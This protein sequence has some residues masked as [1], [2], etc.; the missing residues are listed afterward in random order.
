MNVTISNQAATDTPADWLLLGITESEELGEALQTIDRALG[1]ILTRLQERGDLT[2]KAN[3]L[4]LLP[5]V[6]G[7]QAD[8]MMIVGLGPADRMSRASFAKSMSTAIRRV[9]TREQQTLA[10]SLPAVAQKQF[11]VSSLLECLTDLATVHGSGAGLYK[12]EQERFPLKSCLFT[13]ISESAEHRQA[14]ERGRTIGRAVNLVRELV[15]R[16]PDELYPETFADQAADVAADL[17]IRGEILDEH[18]LDEERMGAMLAVARGSDRPPRLVV[19]KYRGG[20]A[21]APTLA[22]VGKGVTFD[23]GGLS[24]KTSQGMISMKADMAGAATV[25]GA[26]SAIA[27]L[28]IPVNVSGYLGLVENMT[29]GK[30]YKLGSVLT[31]RN[32]KTIEVHNTDAEGRLVLADVL[33]YAVDEQAA[34]IIDLATLTGSCVVALGED[35]VGAFAN[36]QDWCDDLLTSAHA[37][38]E[39]AWQMPMHDFYSEQLKSEFADCKNVGTRWG[40]AITAAKFLEQFVG[41]TPWVHLDIAG[42][43]YAESGSAHRDPGGTG[44]MVRSLV[45]LASQMANAPG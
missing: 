43:A 12:A 35:V 15:N 11:G 5:D 18:Q 38:G 23:S 7:L 36:N 45:H 33:S 8:R 37:V 30:A 26:I 32:G 19:L 4:T 42:P 34:K 2:G 39:L 31:A 41:E 27:R 16:H 17:G 3:E 1:G 6:S 13:G 25:L 22:L 28:K 20:G 24:I 44:V 14:M 21:Q 29:G 40:G 9:T 10:I